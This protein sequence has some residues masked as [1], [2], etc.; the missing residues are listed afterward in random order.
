MA[1]VNTQNKE[2]EL[3]GLGGKIEFKKNGLN[4]FFLKQ[5][6]LNGYTFSGSIDQI[7]ADEVYQ[8]PT[9]GAIFWDILK[10]DKL[11]ITFKD[12]NGK[13][14]RSNPAIER[15]LTKE[16]LER[17]KGYNTKFYQ[18]YTEAKNIENE[19]TIDEDVEIKYKGEDEMNKEVVNKTTVNEDVKEEVAIGNA[20]PNIPQCVLDFMAEYKIN[21]V[22]KTL[23]L[24][25]NMFNKSKAEIVSLNKTLELTKS[26]PAVVRELTEEEIQKLVYENIPSEYMQAL[27]RVL[28]LGCEATVLNDKIESLEKSLETLKEERDNLFIENDNLSSDNAILTDNLNEITTT[29]ITPEDPDDDPK[30]GQPIPVDYSVLKAELKSE[31]IAELREEFKALSPAPAPIQPKIEKPIQ[32]T[33]EEIKKTPNKLNLPTAKET[34]LTTTKEE[35]KQ[36]IKKEE[37]NKPQITQKKKLDLDTITY[38]ELC[39]QSYQILQK[40]GSVLKLGD[41]NV[42]KKDQLIEKI[43][44]K[45]NLTKVSVKTTDSGMKE[46][47]QTLNINKTTT[48]AAP[49]VDYSAMRQNNTTVVDENISSIDE[50]L[51]SGIEETDMDR[52]TNAKFDDQNQQ[53]LANF[54]LGK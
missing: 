29:N 52:L 34:A 1:L 33:K 35:P 4:K 48:V 12:E 16:I 46:N 6:K 24:A 10:Y 32:Q 15:E 49:T 2:N 18:L 44:A 41:A 45:L 14:L 8:G 43:A 23:E 3:I 7:K 53:D 19:S 54:L 9:H 13:P 38:E 31:I 20:K 21:N 36:Q 30:G 40:I 17:E 51:V 5:Q 26:K 42:A 28:E 11:T 47:K 25:I 37:I 39:E 27:D 22:G 50:L